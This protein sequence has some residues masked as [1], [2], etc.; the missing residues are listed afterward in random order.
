MNISPLATKKINH[1]GTKHTKNCTKRAQP[2]SLFVLFFVCFVPW[3]LNF[4]PRLEPAR[5]L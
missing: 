5:N 4:L 2:F 3:W 1:E